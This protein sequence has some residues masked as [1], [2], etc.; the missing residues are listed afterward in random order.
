LFE[1][2]EVAVTVGKVNKLSAAALVA[3]FAAV[4]TTIFPACGVASVVIVILVAVFAVIVQA[5]PFKVTEVAEAKFVPVM[6]IV[7]TVPVQTLAGVNEL[8]TGPGAA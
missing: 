4:V 2:S 3:L 1:A 8:I 6:V 7:P 5:S